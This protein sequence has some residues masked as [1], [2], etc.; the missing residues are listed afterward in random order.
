MRIRISRRLGLAVAVR[1]VAARGDSLVFPGDRSPGPPCRQPPATPPRRRRPPR[2]PRR[3]PR[4]R[5]RARGRRRIPRI[6]RPRRCRRGGRGGMRLRRRGLRGR[7]RRALRDERGLPGRRT[8]RRTF[9]S[10]VLASVVAHTSVTMMSSIFE[11]LHRAS[12]ADRCSHDRRSH[13]RAHSECRCEQYRPFPFGEL[14]VSQCLGIFETLEN[15][16]E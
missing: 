15:D 5:R 3:R 8:V 16:E 13:E 2:I 4:L 9:S 1:G 7:V 6:R 10:V 14:T 12:T 11:S